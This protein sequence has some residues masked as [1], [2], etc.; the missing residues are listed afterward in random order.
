MDAGDRTSLES[1]NSC[2]SPTPKKRAMDTVIFG[3]QALARQRSGRIKEKDFVGDGSKRR[4][5][6]ISRFLDLGRESRACFP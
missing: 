5:R 3:V 2:S 1:K 4:V 6:R